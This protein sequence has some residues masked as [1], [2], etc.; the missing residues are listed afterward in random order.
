MN[1]S[2]EPKSGPSGNG[3]AFGGARRRPNEG[4]LGLKPSGRVASPAQ[5]P[6]APAREAQVVDP[7]FFCRDVS[8]YY[9]AKQALKNVIIDVGPQQV[10]AMIGPSGC[11]KSTFLRCLNR[12]NDTIPGARVTGSI[13]L[14]GQ[15]IHDRR[16]RC[17]AAAR[18]HRHGV[19]EAQSVSQVHLRQRRLRAAHPRAR[20]AAA[21]SSMNSCAQPAR[22]PGSGTRSRIA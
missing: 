15:D 19:P 8:V 21:S 11:G 22:A 9:G 10:L 12:M 6:S 18:P 20:R 7:V 4:G 17:G 5:D 3:A 16:A 13:L 14:D 1:D 2:L